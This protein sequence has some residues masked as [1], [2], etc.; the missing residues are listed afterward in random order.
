MEV[1]GLEERAS[2]A[3]SAVRTALSM[4]GS[5]GSLIG[6]IMAEGEAV[7]EGTR[8]QLRDQIKVCEDELHR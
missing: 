6:R 8:N 4:L 5:W 2:A 3:D 1:A 7:D